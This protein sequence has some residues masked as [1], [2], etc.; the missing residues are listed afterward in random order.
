[1]TDGGTPAARGSG[2]T[3][4]MATAAPAR[5]PVNGPSWASS[6]RCDRSRA[7]MN[8]QRCWFLEECARRPAR[9]IRSRCAGS[10]GR[11]AKARIARLLAMAVQTGSGCVTKPT[12]RAVGRVGRRNGR[13]R[14]GRHLR[15]AGEGD[16]GEG[17][18]TTRRRRDGVEPG[19]AVGDSLGRCGCRDAPCLVG[20]ER[21][22]ERGREEPGHDLAIAR[23]LVEPRVLAPVD[24][25]RLHRG[26]VRVVVARRAGGRRE[27][28]SC[29]SAARPCPRSRGS[30][31]PGRGTG[32]WLPWR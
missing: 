24:D 26:R 18:E 5:W 3:R 19:L 25:D 11:S 28:S 32:R 10:R 23:V 6:R 21:T 17:A 7:T 8:D 9:R 13:H 29:G 4:A 12:R 1:M 2:V 20:G 31:G 15:R 16:L 27:S 14:D 30:A 22:A